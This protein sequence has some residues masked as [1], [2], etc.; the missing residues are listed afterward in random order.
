MSAYHETLDQVVSGYQ[1]TEANLSFARSEFNRLCASHFTANIL[2][3]LDRFVECL[4]HQGV[5]INL[6]CGAQPVTRATLAI[7]GPATSL[8]M[9]IVSYEFATRSLTFDSVLGANERETQEY[10]TLGQLNEVKPA[11]VYSIIEN[12]VYTVFESDSLCDY[13]D[14][15]DELSES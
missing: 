3:E 1:N 13:Q 14:S 7:E 6:L 15:E 11:L 9:L 2:P 8:S 10:F 4:R 5:R 12:F